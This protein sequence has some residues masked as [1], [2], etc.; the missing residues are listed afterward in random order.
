[1]NNSENQINW[2]EE[3]NV[4]LLVVAQKIAYLYELFVF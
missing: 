4:L 2:R 3:Y 1:M